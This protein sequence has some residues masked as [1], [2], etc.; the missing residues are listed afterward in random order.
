M[1]VTEKLIVRRRLR[2]ELSS[3]RQRIDDER[4]PAT[5]AKMFNVY[6][7]KNSCQVM[8]ANIE[9]AVILPSA[10]ITRKVE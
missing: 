7:P 5:K 1:D 9:C 3:I 10:K 2:I 8:C 6:C 4:N